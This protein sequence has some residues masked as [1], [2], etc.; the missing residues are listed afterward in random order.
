MEAG[1]VDKTLEERGESYGDFSVGTEEYGNILASLN[2]VHESKNGSS[3]KPRDLVALGYIVMKLIRLAATPN[4]SDS[5]HDIQGYAKLSE[6]MYLN[7]KKR[8]ALN[9][10]DVSNL[11]SSSKGVQENVTQN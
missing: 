3:L 10:L 2:V 4:H 6:K 8:E 9:A 1:K 7:D 11:R 5:W